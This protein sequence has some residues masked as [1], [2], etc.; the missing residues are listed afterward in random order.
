MSKDVQSHLELLGY[1]VKDKVT[2]VKGVVVAVSFDLYGCIQAL[3]DVSDKSNYNNKRWFDVSRLDT[4]KQV[5]KYTVSHKFITEVMQKLA[6]ALGR[7]AKSLIVKDTA[8]I[9]SIA[10]TVSGNTW[11]SVHRGYGADK[12]AKDVNWHDYVT[13]KPLGGAS[14]M[15]LP[16]YTRGYI[17]K[18]RQGPA[19]KST[20]MTL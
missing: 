6:D 16:N 3:V 12:R 1:R 10:F 14:V 17:A 18:G 4:K 13:F 2:G 19:E 8:V 20:N 9:T 7:K 15:K 5:I 11:T